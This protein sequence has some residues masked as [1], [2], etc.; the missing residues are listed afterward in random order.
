[1]CAFNFELFRMSDKD[2][3][4]ICEYV[5]AKFDKMVLSSP[6]QPEPGGCCRPFYPKQSLFRSSHSMRHD[7][8]NNQTVDILPI[9][10]LYLP[11]NIFDSGGTYIRHLYDHLTINRP[12]ADEISNTVFF[13]TRILPILAQIYT[14]S[15]K[16]RPYVTVGD[17][18]EDARNQRSR[19]FIIDILKAMQTDSAI[20][21]NNNTTDVT[22]TVT[23]VRKKKK[24]IS[25]TIRKLVW[26]THIGEEIGKA[27]CLCCKVTDITQLSFN[28]GHIVAEA[29]GGD[30]IVSNL[31]PICQNCNSSMGTKDMNEFM[32]T[33]K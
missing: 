2:F 20:L 1:M 27:K 31:K 10:K 5:F 8:L 33:L 14:S 21:V 25:A 30:T 6:P 12:F 15:M 13:D 29:N 7:A 24:N 19:H 26:N 9:V 22:V 3:D 32:K 11:K 23:V 17:H 16:Y 28:C 4:S 18:V